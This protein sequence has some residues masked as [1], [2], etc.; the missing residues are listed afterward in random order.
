MDP[1]VSAA[2]QALV[3]MSGGVDSSVAAYL[4]NAQ[5]IRC[6]G[7]TM[8]LYDNEDVGLTKAHACCT[9]EDALD[10]RAVA[11][12]LGMKHYVF[13]YRARFDETVIRRFIEAYRHGRTPNPCIDCNRFLKFGALLDQARLLGCAFAAT[14]HYARVKFDAGSGRWLLKT[15]LDAG[16]DQSYVLYSMTQAQLAH[17]RF[18]L[19]ALTKAQVREIAVQQGFVNARKY[20][21][22]DICFAPDG[23]YAGFIERHTGKAC[24]PGDFVDAGGKVLGR[25]RGIIH[26]TIGQRRGLG[27]SFPQ[28]MYVAGIDPA[29]NTVTLAPEEGLYTKTLKAHDLNFIAC[30]SLPSPVRVQA[31]VRYRHAAQPARVWQEGED[32]LRVEFD[33]PQRAVTPGQAVVLYDGETV[34]GGGTID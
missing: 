25:H 34:V 7:V 11:Y 23:D 16:K 4:L 10:A 19:G 30:A 28:P 14:G 24:P 12:A 15:G 2:P 6:I 32:C 29:R 26:Y 18:P 5:G 13:N 31:K 20:D 33:T 27:L 3:A 22:Q 9:L 1:F 17:V 21:S 8:K